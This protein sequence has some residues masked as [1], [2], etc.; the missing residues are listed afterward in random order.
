MHIPK[1]SATQSLAIDGRAFSLTLQGRPIPGTQRPVVP[2]AGTCSCYTPNDDPT[3]VTRV[4]NCG[5][6]YTPDCDLTRPTNNDGTYQF[7]RC[8]CY[9]Q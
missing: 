3:D 6:G 7:Y 1:F 5:Q 8:R 4:N 9:T 2:P